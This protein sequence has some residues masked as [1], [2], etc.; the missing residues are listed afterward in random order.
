MIISGDWMRWQLTPISPNLTTLHTWLLRVT[1]SKPLTRLTLY[2]Y[3]PRYGHTVYYGIDSNE[4]A[5]KQNYSGNL[6]AVV[7]V[8]FPIWY[9]KIES[10]VAQN[11]GTRADL[12]VYTGIYGCGRWDRC[13]EWLFQLCIVLGS[14]WLTCNKQEQ[15]PVVQLSTSA[16]ENHLHSVDYLHT[17]ATVNEIKRPLYRQPNHHSNN[18]IYSVYPG[19][20]PLTLSYLSTNVYHTQLG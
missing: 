7:V 10:L 8:N 9:R 12:H 4:F 20:Y 17:W 3:S 18:V 16:G 13:P 11:V 19:M 14:R 5:L 1:V 15:P 2:M 6:T